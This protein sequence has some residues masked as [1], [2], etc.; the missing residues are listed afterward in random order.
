MFS[1]GFAE[2]VM[3]E[4][5]NSAAQNLFAVSVTRFRPEL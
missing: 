1:L 4:I 2:R 5:Q 3:R